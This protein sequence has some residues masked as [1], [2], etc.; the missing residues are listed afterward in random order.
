MEVMMSAPRSAKRILILKIGA[1]IGCYSAT[2]LPIHEL[3][4][5]LWDV[6]LHIPSP[7]SLVHVGS[8]QLRCARVMISA[9]HAGCCMLGEQSLRGRRV[10]DFIVVKVLLP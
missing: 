7:E 4:V 10:I 2:I 9:Y 3:Q 6:S 8:R 1:R 5:Q